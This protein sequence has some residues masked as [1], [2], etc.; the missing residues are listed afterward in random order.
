MEIDELGADARMD[1]LPFE[2]RWPTERGLALWRSGD[3]ETAKAS[4]EI[5]LATAHEVASAFGV[6]HALHLR[7]CVA[8]SERDY[9]RFGSYFQYEIDA[10]KPLELNYRVWVQGGEMTVPQVNKLAEAFTSPAEVKVK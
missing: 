2:V 1:R 7:A 9:G 6:F 4:L 5:A 3:L 8:F 10:K